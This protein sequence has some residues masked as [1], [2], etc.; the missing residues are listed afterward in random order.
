MR[1][2]PQ[3]LQARLDSGTTQLC[4]CWKI[5]R[6]DGVILGFTDHDRDLTFE[7]VTFAASTGLDAGALEAGTG[8]SVDNGQ[9]VGALT[10]AAINETDIHAGRY[11]GAEIRQWLVDWSAPNLRVFMFCGTLGEIRLADGRF[12]VE[13]R[14]LTE[15]LNQSVGRTVVRRCDCLL[16]DTRCGVDTSI[17]DYSTETELRDGSTGGTLLV[18]DLGGFAENWFEHGTV[19]FLSGDNV[20][21]SFSIR[22]EISRGAGQ[23]QLD[24]W[25]DPPLAVSVGD[26]LR[27]VAGCD[28]RFETC[29]A[30][31]ANT[32]NFRGFPH[33]P[34][35]DWVTAYP[36]QGE[37]HDGQRRR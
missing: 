33:I 9:A 5:S 20:G 1:V 29:R 2:I 26:R 14:G 28:K 7:D 13:L 30:K 34:G 3:E 18:G 24:L 15:R 19:V 8:L 6:T 32:L 22:S 23:R 10:A 21:L 17:T 27:L 16:G 4:R 36:K 11:D 31:F 35:E 37:V 25:R 12:E